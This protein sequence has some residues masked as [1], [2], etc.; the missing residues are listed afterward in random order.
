MN[1]STLQLVGCP[2]CLTPA[3]ITDR[4]VLEST[5]GPVEHVTVW[6]ANRHRFT[7]TIDHLSS[8]SRRT[9]PVRRTP[10]TR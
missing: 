4:F 6:C 8:R 2:Q 9:E 5:S 1:G 3:E 7:T 10:A